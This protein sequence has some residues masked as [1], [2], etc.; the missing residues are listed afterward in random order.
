MGD[1]MYDVVI[2]GAGASGLM[3][4]NI[5]KKENKNI[6]VLLLE[7]NDKVG[8]KLSITGNGKCNLGNS[9]ISEDKYNM[10]KYY[11]GMIKYEKDYLNYLKSFGI[12]LKEDKEGRIYPYNEQAIS[13]CKM[14]EKNLKYRS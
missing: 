7:K 5:L 13:V 1:V 8:K 2:V 3:L 11:K 14:F 4:A 10:N 9:F 12:L 6:S